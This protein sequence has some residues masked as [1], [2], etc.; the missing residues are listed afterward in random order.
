MNLATMNPVLFDF[1]LVPEPFRE[2]PAWF[3]LVPE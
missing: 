1:R 2:D 3:R